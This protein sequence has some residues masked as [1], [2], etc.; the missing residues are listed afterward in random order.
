ML[1]QSVR[2]GLDEVALVVQGIAEALGPHEPREVLAQMAEPA[3]R[4]QAHVV[5]RVRLVPLQ[6]ARDGRGRRIG[7]GVGV[8]VR[9]ALD[10]PVALVLEA[11]TPGA[12]ERGRIGDG[13]PEHRHLQIYAH[14]DV[15]EAAEPLN[16]ETPL[17][18]IIGITRRELGQEVKPPGNRVADLRI[19]K[20]LDIVYAAGG[21]LAPNGGHQGFPIWRKRFRESLVPVHGT[22]LAVRARPPASDTLFAGR[23]Q[24]ENA[25]QHTTLDGQTPDMVY[26]A[27]QPQRKAS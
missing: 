2:D 10:G 6:L 14:R 22:L 23:K 13:L 21:P 12:V 15:V 19:L 16:D 8:E 24:S 27:L 20:Q 9:P 18:V 25:K 3:L 26:F 4:D 1:D 11:A 7:P 17:A 5:G